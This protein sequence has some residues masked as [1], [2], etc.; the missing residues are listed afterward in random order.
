MQLIGR[1]EVISQA[2]AQ[3]VVFVENRKIEFF[4]GFAHLF[5]QAQDIVAH[6]ARTIWPSIV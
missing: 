3:D 4:T 2:K 6:T 1:R 5:V